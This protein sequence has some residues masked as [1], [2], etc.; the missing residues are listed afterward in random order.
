MP[1]G[2]YL[3]GKTQKLSLE[4]LLDR[5]EELEIKIDAIK[6]QTDKLAG[7]SPIVGSSTEDWQAAEADV[8][9]IGAAG[10]RYKLHSLVVFIDN[11]VGTAITVRMFMQKNGT[12]VKVYDQTFDATTDPLGLWLVNGTVE[13]DNALRVTLQSN[14]SADNGKVADYRY[15]TEA[16]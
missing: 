11:L 4:S 3:E 10:V 16:M 6:T 2:F 13:I 9:S 5:L 7:E 15:L 1:G 14:N 12:E 8:V